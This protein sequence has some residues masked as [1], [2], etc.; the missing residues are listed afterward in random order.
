M[1]ELLSSVC[2]FSTGFCTFPSVCAAGTDPLTEQAVPLA[3][4]PIIWE[5]VTAELG[6]DTAVES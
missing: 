1:A 6:F 3:G 2:S 4:K 5:Q